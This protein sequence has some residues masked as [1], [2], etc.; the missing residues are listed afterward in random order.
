AERLLAFT[1]WDDCDPLAGQ[2]WWDVITGGAVDGGFI[3][4]VAWHRA[5]GRPRGPT[6]PHARADARDGWA[7]N[8]LSAM[9]ALA[10]AHA[11]VMA[12]K[13]A[14]PAPVELPPGEEDG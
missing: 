10:E 9:D 7:R 2:L 11:E 6:L 1:R 12:K 8:A 4:E 14:A 3:D 13:R 5:M